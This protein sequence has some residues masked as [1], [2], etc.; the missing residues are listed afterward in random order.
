MNILQKNSTVD[1]LFLEGALDSIPPID[2][3]GTK[4]S[5]TFKADKPEGKI[6]LV[7]NA[8]IITMENDTSH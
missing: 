6:A 5:L 2:T 4:I 8:N 7:K 3:V 1:F